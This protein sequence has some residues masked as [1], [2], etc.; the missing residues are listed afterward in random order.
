VEAL[1]ALV[2][3]IGIFTAICFLAGLAL[4]IIEMFAP[5]FGLPGIGGCILLLLGIFFTAQTITQVLILLILILA[6]LGICL[7]VIIHSAKNGK[8]SKS[9][10]LS[11]TMDKDD[12]V[13]REKDMEYFLGKEGIVVTT[14]RPV[15]NAD[16]HGVKLQ[17]VAEG[18]FITKGTRVK[19]IKV[20][21]KNIVVCKN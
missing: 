13:I 1:T 18:E 9:V 8:L 10:I 14:L 16:F 19:V 2:N 11:T 21:G 6:I 12:G 7:S 20:E 3:N 4:I 5:G 17:V 15:G